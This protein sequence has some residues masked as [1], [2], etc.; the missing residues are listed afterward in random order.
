MPMTG[1]PVIGWRQRLKSLPVAGSVLVWLYRRWNRMRLEPSWRGRLKNTPFLGDLIYWIWM[2]LTLPRFKR[3]V[4]RHMAEVQ[5]QLQSQRQEMEAFRLD[6]HARLERQMIESQER[7]SAEQHRI[8]A[9]LEDLSRHEQRTDTLQV[10]LNQY[11]ERTAALEDRW[12]QHQERLGSLQESFGT[13]QQR[14]AALQHGMRLLENQAVRSDLSPKSPGHSAD[15]ASLFAANLGNFYFEFETRFRGARN[16][17]KERLLP[18]LPYVR[19]A[20]GRSVES[21]RCVDIGCGRGEWLDLLREQE[22]PAVGIDIDASMV[23]YCRDLGHEVIHE[24]AIL[25]LGAQPAQSIDVLSGFQIA[26]HLPFDLLIQLLDQ[27][28]RV[29]KPKG[30][31]ILETPN[32]ENLQVGACNFYYDPTHQRPLPPPVFA[33]LAEQRG[34]KRAEILRLNPYPLEMHIPHAGPVT[35]RMNQL[36]YGPQDYALIAGA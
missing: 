3:E 29:L 7:L 25:W 11:Q 32:P 36:I 26:E 5:G 21:A 10:G 31:L 27:A 28:L 33:F 12:I 15:S 19:T 1:D 14:V 17:I 18:Y 24:D 13:H 2:I 30:V 16:Q 22:I 6:V 35:E 34:F 4:L 23:L 8:N 20:V 9:L